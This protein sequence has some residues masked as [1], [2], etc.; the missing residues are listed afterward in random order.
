MPH[1]YPHLLRHAPVT[2]RRRG[3]WQLNVVI[4]LT[5]RG[6]LI[7]L[8]DLWGLTKQETV[9]KLISD[10]SVKG[11]TDADP[12]NQPHPRLS[13][14]TNIGGPGTVVGG[15]GNDPAG[16]SASD[17]SDPQLTDELLEASRDLTATEAVP[18]LEWP[19]PVE[20]TGAPDW[21]ALMEAGKASRTE[22]LIG[23]DEPT[24]DDI[25]HIA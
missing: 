9:R 13:T 10:A 11:A 3:G 18:R 23:A 17:G 20:E 5:Q 4:S 21:D 14:E 15:S 7:R 6:M 19:R 22:P 2:E 24:F 8:A 25:E 1:T 12:D 16:I